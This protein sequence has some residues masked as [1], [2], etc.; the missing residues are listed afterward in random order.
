MP[1]YPQKRE[2]GH[3]EAVSF[4][5][6]RGEYLRTFHHSPDKAWKR[7]EGNRRHTQHHV[8]DHT[9]PKKEGK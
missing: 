4:M 6:H 9:P 3:F 2:R 7:L 5:P 1:N 8:I